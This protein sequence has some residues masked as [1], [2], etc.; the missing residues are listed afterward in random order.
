MHPWQKRRYVRSIILLGVLL[1]A[2]LYLWLTKPAQRKQF[3]TKSV[4]VE[5]AFVKTTWAVETLLD[6]QYIPA[7]FE[8]IESSKRSIDISMYVIRS[9]A[10]S[11]TVNKIIELIGEAIKRGVKVRVLLDRPDD[12]N[13]PHFGFNLNA[14]AK[15]ALKGADVRFDDPGIELHE[16]LVIFDRKD[17]IIGAHNWTEDALIKNRE[18]SVLCQPSQPIG[19]TESSFEKRWKRSTPISKTF[20]PGEIVNS[21]DELEGEGQ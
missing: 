21:D 12:I 4:P 8:K 18:I 19:E 7:L 16:K 6:S 5:N 10:A 14:G 3:H 9:D 17:F 20:G 11:I 2:L 1:C 15:L 13:L